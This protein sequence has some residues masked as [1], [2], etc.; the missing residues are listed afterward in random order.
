MQLPQIKLF[1]I[2]HQSHSSTEHNRGLHRR[3]FFQSIIASQIAHQEHH[4]PSPPT[5]RQLCLYSINIRQNI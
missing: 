1:P 3:L 5:I 2:L 4:L